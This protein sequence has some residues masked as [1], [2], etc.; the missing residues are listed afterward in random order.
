[1]NLKK[2][3]F[4]F[5][6]LQK[7]NFLGKSLD[8]ISSSLRNALENKMNDNELSGEYRLLRIISKSNTKVVFDVGANV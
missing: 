4:H 6:T 7:R 5:I 1:M 8:K 3:L 2:K